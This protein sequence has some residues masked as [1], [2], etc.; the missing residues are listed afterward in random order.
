VLSTIERGVC[1]HLFH[2]TETKQYMIADIK[3]EM[4]ELVR[5]ENLAFPGLYH[6]FPDGRW[7]LAKPNVLPF[8]RAE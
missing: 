5:A 6:E 3:R 2:D 8:G 1:D 7:G 4:C